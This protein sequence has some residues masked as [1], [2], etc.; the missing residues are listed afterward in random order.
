[1]CLSPNDANQL[2]LYLAAP[3]VLAHMPARTAGLVTQ[4][5]TLPA[6]L[7]HR[8]VC[9]SVC[10]TVCMCSSVTMEVLRVTAHP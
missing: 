4:V 1:M 10:E 5:R 8:T 7:G 6:S 2:S 3:R 9:G